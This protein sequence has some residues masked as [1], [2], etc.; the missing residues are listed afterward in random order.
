MA[1]L[2]SLV[3]EGD[4]SPVCCVATCCRSVCFFGCDILLVNLHGSP[5]CFVLTDEDGGAFHY[6]LCLKA[7]SP[8]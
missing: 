3:R 6:T 5:V 4:V 8:S 1:G 2:V 7:V